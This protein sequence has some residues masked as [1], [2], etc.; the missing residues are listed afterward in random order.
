[1]FFKNGFL[2][3]GFQTENIYVR[4][5]NMCKWKKNVRVQNSKYEFKIIK[6]QR[7]SWVRE[8]SAQVSSVVQR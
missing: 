6:N 7:F 8:S 5:I 1:M 2:K 3:N 4:V